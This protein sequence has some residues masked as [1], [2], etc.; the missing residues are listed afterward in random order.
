MTKPWDEEGYDENP[1]WTR[2]DFA[3]AIPFSKLPP[4]MQKK[5]LS[6]REAKPAPLTLADQEVTVCAEEVVK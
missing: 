1:E 4:D 6:V 5:L 2:E 3:K